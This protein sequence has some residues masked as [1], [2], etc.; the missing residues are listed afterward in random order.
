MGELESC[1]QW[2]IDNKL[3][4]NLGKTEAILIVSKYKL[5]R[6]NSFAVRCGEIKA[7]NVKS[8]KYLCL[9]IDND[10]S[11]KSVLEDIIKRCNT[12]LKFLYRYNDMLNLEVRKTLCAALIQCSFDYSCCSWFPGINETFKKKLQVMQNKMIRFIL[13][14]DNRAHIGNDELIRAGFLSV[15]DR[16]KQLKLGHVFKIWNKTCPSYLSENFSR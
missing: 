6:V 1:R 13:R 7:T 5:K 11:G 16:I 15:S 12:R 2:L 10:L 8:V 4:L 9:Q 3:S 14:L